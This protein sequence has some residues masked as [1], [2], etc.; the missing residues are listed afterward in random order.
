MT[1]FRLA[2][3]LFGVTAWLLLHVGYVSAQS[4]E[5]EVPKVV[6]TNVPFDVKVVSKDLGDDAAVVTLQV[7]GTEIRELV[8][9][10]AATFNGVVLRDADAELSLT[11]AGQQLASANPIVLP[12]WASIVP[13]FLAILIALVFRQV[14]P[15]IFSGV[16]VGAWLVNGFTLSGMWFGLLDSVQVYVLNSLAD[17]G[18]LSV[19]VFSLMI[20]GMIGIISAN[21]GTIGIVNSIVGFANSARRGQATTGLLGVAIFFDDYANTLIVGNTM[22]PVTDRL[23]ISREKLAYIVDSTAAPV[24]A[25]ALVTTWIGYEVGLIDASVRTIEGY[26]EAAYSIFLSSIPYSFYPILAVLFVFAVA[27]LRRDFGPMYKAERRAWSDGLVMRPGAEIGQSNAESEAV[28][29]KEGKPQ[30][31]INAVIPVLVLVGGTLVGIYITGAEGLDPDAGLRTII[32]NG[33][34]YKSLVWASLLGVL[35]AA[36]LSVGQRILTLG[37]VIE[38]WY[39]GLKSMMF[40]VIILILAWSLA[41]VDS[42]LNTGGYLVTVLGDQISPYILPAAVFMLSA[43]TAFATGS[44]WGVMGIVMPLVV[45]L[46]W[47]VMEM[48]GLTNDPANMHILYSSVAAVL[49]GAVWGD[50]C[51]PISDTT[52]LSSMASGCDHVDHV[53]TQLP[54]AMTVGAVAVLIGI[55]PVGYGL[56]WWVGM[57]LGFVV[58]IS[59]LL[60][61][62]RNVETETTPAVDA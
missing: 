32:G 21:G 55:V 17:T 39:A 1:R 59:I 30:R 61:L 20:G 2:I 5:L 18:N 8:R 28:K 60:T 22:R 47:A 4:A 40:A 9:D 35:V 54:Y 41:N 26:N 24:S 49:A 56:P 52:I 42:V 46:A 58:L 57:A 43:L 48:N 37:E 50:H 36:L 51:S 27:L 62:G 19:L 45:P 7:N 13:A 38:S 33:D 29:A 53:R 15:A 23:R 31:A 11:Y 25:I 10:G 44:S 14:I 16:W 12:G 34:S 3:S 6:L